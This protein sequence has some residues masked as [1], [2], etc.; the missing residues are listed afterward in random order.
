MYV[1]VCTNIKIQPAG[2]VLLFVYILFQAWQL[3][4]RQP[5]RACTWERLNPLSPSGHQS[6]VVPRLGVE[7][8]GIPPVH[9]NMAIDIAMATVLFAQTFLGETL[10]F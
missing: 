6:S 7:P 4:T 5:G 10:K 1:H 8:C 2:S 3:C 9:L